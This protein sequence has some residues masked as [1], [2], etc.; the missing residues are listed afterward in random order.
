MPWFDI[1][2]SFTKKINGK[3]QQLGRGVQL[4]LHLWWK[5]ASWAFWPT[6]GVITR[7]GGVLRARSVGRVQEGDLRCTPSGRPGWGGPAAVILSARRQGGRGEPLQDSHVRREAVTP[8]R[9]SGDR[10]DSAGIPDPA[11]TSGGN[12]IFPPSV[13]GL[14][15]CVLLGATV[16]CSQETEILVY[17]SLKPVDICPLG[18]S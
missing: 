3:L 5:A 17:Q 8:S 4:H 12:C 6:A 15:T 9:L 13:L 7:P 16:I 11:T 10:G 2:F 14:F 18:R 1:S